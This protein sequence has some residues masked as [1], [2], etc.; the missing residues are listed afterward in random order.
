MH[1]QLSRPE[2]LRRS[3]DLVLEKLRGTKRLDLFECA[4]VDSKYQ[5]EEIVSN[6]AVLVKEGKFDHI[7]LSECRAETVR[8]ANKASLFLDDWLL[9]KIT[10]HYSV[11][12][13]PIASV[14]IEVSPWS[15]EEETK[16][17][18]LSSYPLSSG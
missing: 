3:V 18:A 5:I 1:V 7:G 16:Q 6:L 13:H 8:R 14:E 10:N 17:G 4:R 9:S 15:Y 11:Q 12:V 2:N